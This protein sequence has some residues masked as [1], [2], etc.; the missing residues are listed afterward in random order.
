[1]LV[2]NGTDLDDVLQGDAGNEVFYGLGGADTIEGGAGNDTIEGGLGNDSLSGGEG[3]DMLSYMQASGG[4]VLRLHHAGSAEGADGSDRFLYGDWPFTLDFEDARGSPFADTIHGSTGANLLRGSGGDDLIFGNGGHDTLMGGNGADTLSGAAGP[5]TMTG[6]LHADLFGIPVHGYFP[7]ATVL[8]TVT[9][10][11]DFNAAE[12]DRLRL[13]TVQAPELPP[14]PGSGSSGGG[15]TWITYEPTY[16]GYFQ[17]ARGYLPM[18]WAGTAAADAP[19]LGMALPMAELAQVA[20]LAAWIA[21][22]AGG[23]WVAFDLDADGRLG[24]A[25]RLLRL[26]A[27]GPLAIGQD[28]FLPDVFRPRQVGTDG[29]DLLIGNTLPDHLLNS[30]YFG[31]N[32]PVP[33]RDVLIGGAGADTLRGGAGHDTLTGGEGAD[34]LEGGFHDD[35]VIEAAN[36]GTDQVFAAVSFVLAAHVERLTLTEAAGAATGRGN[37]LDNGLVGNDFDNRLAGGDGKDGLSGGGGHDSLYGEAGGDTLLGGT[38]NDL[39]DGAD[40]ADRLEGGLGSDLLRGGAGHDT[41]T[42]EVGQQATLMG[43]EGDDQ[44]ATAA[45]NSDPGIGNLLIGGTGNDRYEVRDHDLVAERAGEGADTITAYGTRETVIL[46][47]HVEALVIG[48][49]GRIGIGN[50][51]GNRLHGDY[52]AQRLDG[53]AG[54]DTLYG[55]SGSD[56]LIGGAGADVFEFTAAHIGADVVLDFTPG[57]DRIALHDIPNPLAFARDT[58]AGALIEYAYGFATILLAGV[59]RAE[60]AAADFVLG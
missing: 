46:P 28:A 36:A 55:S 52:D 11:T 30:V 25:D 16:T 57:E 1:M 49:A 10:I 33:E 58:E 41:L 3:R 2:R 54:A 17:G 5:L 39:L 48:G 12:G 7:G 23:G 42:I 6:G 18:I 21:D 34:R 31:A 19:S 47:A 43:G 20:Y 4:V 32:M 13:A 44:L 37:A 59:A 24:T 29:N 50:A 51:G 15:W 60:L 8:T 56:T 27:T 26:D 45:W 35:R 14:P 53:M 40:G 38:G 9:Q 22:P